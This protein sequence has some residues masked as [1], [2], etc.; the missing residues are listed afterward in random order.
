[1]FNK[2]ADASRYQYRGLLTTMGSLGRLSEKHGFKVQQRRSVGQVISLTKGFQTAV[3]TVDSI[4]SDMRHR[5][6]L[7]KA[8]WAAYAW[9]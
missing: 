9:N 3:N 6:N 8:G 4:R 2:P 5:V 7:C 1:M